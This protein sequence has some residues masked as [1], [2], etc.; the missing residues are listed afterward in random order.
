MAIKRQEVTAVST[1]EAE[2][3]AFLEA[4]REATW[5]RTLYRDIVFSYRPQSL[6]GWISNLLQEKEE[7][8][9]SNTEVEI[10][11]NRE[12]R[13]QQPAATAKRKHGNNGGNS[14]TSGSNSSNSGGNN[15]GKDKTRGRTTTRQHNVPCRA[16]AV[17]TAI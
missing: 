1:Q 17:T 4:G 12:R 6:E 7:E 15:G 5:L 11:P 14:G 16:K 8:E 13:A 3:I 9:S 10:K 2:Y